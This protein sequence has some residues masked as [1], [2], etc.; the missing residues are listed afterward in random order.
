MK[1]KVLKVGFDLD[2]VLLYNPARIFRPIIY[3][4]KKYILKRNTNQFYYPKNKLEQLIWLFLH[5]S[6]LFPAPGVKEIKQLIKEKKIKA[7]V[8]SARYES[9]REDFLFWKKKIDPENLFSSWYYNEKNDQPHLYKEKMIKKLNLDIFVEDNWDIVKYLKTQ[10]SK[11]KSG[12]KTKI[13][14]IYNL[15]DRNI[16]YWY[17]FSSLKEVIK[18]IS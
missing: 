2:G 12:K 3:F 4:I 9:L 17:K 7:Y 8:I 5:K 16:K 13:F 15:L 1:N 14:W 6:S 10:N 11:L 18:K